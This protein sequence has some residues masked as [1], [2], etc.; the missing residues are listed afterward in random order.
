MVW[1][2]M[3]SYIGVGGLLLLLAQPLID[4]K[5]KPNGFYGVRTPKTLSSEDI[6]Y[7]ANEYG[8]RTLRVMGLATAVAAIALTPLNLIDTGV[9]ALGCVI[10]MFVAAIWMAVKDLQYIQ[11]L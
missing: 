2:V 7:K 1:M 4:R 10:V 11:K 9:Y 8:G 6:W 5:V 3:F